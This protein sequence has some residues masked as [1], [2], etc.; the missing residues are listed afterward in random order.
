MYSQI[1]RISIPE[2][3]IAALENFW[4]EEYLPQ[5]VS[6]LEGMKCYLAKFRLEMPYSNKDHNLSHFPVIL[7]V[8]LFPHRRDFMW[9][10]LC[11]IQKVTAFPEFSYHY[12]YQYSYLTHK[13]I[14][15]NYFIQSIKKILVYSQKT[16]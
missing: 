15:I 4:F 1:V 8:S 13:N 3:E 5:S 6:L 14:F 12:R 16:L 9:G 11:L 7:Q 2:A 10:I